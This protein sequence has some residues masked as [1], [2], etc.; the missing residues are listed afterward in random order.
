[1]DMMPTRCTERTLRRL[2]IGAVRS[3][4]AVAIGPLAGTLSD[5]R[6]AAFCIISS[7]N[8]HVPDVVLLYVGGCP[9]VALPGQHR[10]CVWQQ[11]LDYDNMR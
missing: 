11:A 3:S 4:R 2:R 6:R 9:R 7:T 10:L 5:C 1:M 8:G